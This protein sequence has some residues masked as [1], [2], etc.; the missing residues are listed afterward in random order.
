MD[1]EPSAQSP[2]INLTLAIALKKT[3][4]QIPNSSFPV[5]H[6]PISSSRFKYPARDCRHAD[7]AIERSSWHSIVCCIFEIISHTIKSLRSEISQNNNKPPTIPLGREW[8]SG[9]RC[10]IWIK[11]PVQALLC[12]WLVLETQCRYEAP[13]DF[14]GEIRIKTRLLRSGQCGCC[15]ENDPEL[16]VR[17]PRS[18]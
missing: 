16:T 17:E 15:L 13:G 1:T 12:A 10:C 14:S 2:L 11:F 4:K 18:R 6:Y 3:E 5:Q 8:L 7:D 9:L